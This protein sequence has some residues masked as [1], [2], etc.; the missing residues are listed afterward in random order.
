MGRL[1]VEFREDRMVQWVQWLL[2]D[3]RMGP[4]LKNIF[5]D[6]TVKGLHIRLFWVRVALHPM[7]SV[8]EE[9][10]KK[11]FPGGP[12]DKSPPASEETQ[13]PSLVWEDSTCL[14]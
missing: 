9:T 7:T 6:V 3:L 13:V 1:G 12:V 2:P 14:N 10:E 4:Y 5:A 11:G 8:L